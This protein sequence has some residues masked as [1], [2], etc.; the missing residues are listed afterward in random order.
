MKKF[1]MI[2]CGLSL[3]GS[4]GPGVAD[5]G[6]PFNP[7]SVQHANQRPWHGG[8][9]YLPYGQPTAMV[10][11][12]NSYMRQTYAWGV[13]QNLMYP[14]THQFGRSATSPGASPNGSFRATPHWPSHTDQFGLYHVRAPW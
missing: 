11:P 9:Y 10:V 2:L 6:N 7:W 1:L 4:M 8:Y 12:P 3:A 14:Q 13:S 5:A